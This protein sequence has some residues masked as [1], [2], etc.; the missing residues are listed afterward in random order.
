MEHE[1][2]L[3]YLKQNATEPY[4][5]SAESSPQLHTLFFKTHLQVISSSVLM[6]MS[7]KLSNSFKFSN[8]NCICIS[9]PSSVMCMLW[10]FHRWFDHLVNGAKYEAPPHYA[11]SK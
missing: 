1:G 8:Q 5:E 7:P 11:I 4:A 10:T 6:H 3:P 2:L 9:I